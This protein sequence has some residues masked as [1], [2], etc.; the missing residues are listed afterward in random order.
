MTKDE[1]QKLFEQEQCRELAWQGCCHDCQANITV[2]AHI[3]DD[4]ELQISGGA[5]YNPT[6][7]A[8]GHKQVFLKCDTCFDADPSLRD[9]SPVETY[10][11]VVGYLRP[12][13]QFNPGKQAEFDKRVS[14]AEIR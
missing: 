5:L 2:V 4:G 11:R 10:S 6:M 1:L 8:E 12:V 13:Q 3:K 7:D 14:F 9:Y